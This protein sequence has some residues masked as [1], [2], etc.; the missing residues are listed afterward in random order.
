MCR[1]LK[2]V[3]IPS[4]V[5]TIEERAFYISGGTYDSGSLK[6]IYAEA[7]SK[8]SGWH[9][10]WNPDKKTVV[11]GHKNKQETT[12]VK[13]SNPA[14]Y[15]IKNGVLKYYNG[16]D[17][18]IVIPD[19]VT[20]IGKYALANAKTIKTVIIPDSVETIEANAFFGHKNLTSV[21]LGKGV[22]KIGNGA[23]MN[24]KALESVEMENGSLEM[25]DK[26]AFSGCVNLKEIKFPQ[27][28]K[29]ICVRAFYGCKG[30]TENIF[31][32]KSVEI[33]EDS[34]FLGCT[35]AIYA[36]AMDKPVGWVSGVFKNWLGTSRPVKWGAVKTSSGMY[37]RKLQ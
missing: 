30:V 21:K 8:P 12:T 31:I 34:A 5:T 18:N 29:H 14:D 2:S 37:H 33:I 11:W 25:I 1:G 17:E 26:D 6:K 4:S 7:S 19:G 9:E 36:E 22:K 27:S 23:F 3:T 32:P 20:T 35:G 16:K 28:L 24:C 10:N 15:D 13:Q